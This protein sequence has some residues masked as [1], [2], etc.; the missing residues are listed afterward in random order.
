MNLQVDPDTPKASSRKPLFLGF[1]FM[2][3]V[4]YGAPDFGVPYYN[5]SRVYPKTPSRLQNL[6]IKLRNML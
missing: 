3:I 6:L 1:L 5:S 4:E 2:I